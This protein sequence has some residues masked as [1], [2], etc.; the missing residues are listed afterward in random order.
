MSLTGLMRF[1]GFRGLRGRRDRERSTLSLII[2]VL[3][4]AG[5]ARYGGTR[6]VVNSAHTLSE[7]S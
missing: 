2:I 7:L 1:G 3:V 4:F 6:I 5:A